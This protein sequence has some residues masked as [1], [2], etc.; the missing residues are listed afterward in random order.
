VF[1]LPA[2]GAVVLR[3]NWS[4][5]SKESSEIAKN[6]CDFEVDLVVYN[7]QKA[8]RLQKGE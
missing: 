8:K 3:E 4:M 1:S 7:A 5:P 2:F 6:N